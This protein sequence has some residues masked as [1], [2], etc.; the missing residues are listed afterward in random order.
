MKF[1]ENFKTA[2]LAGLVVGLLLGVVDATA[3]ISVLSFEW[4]EL[5]QAILIPSLMFIVGFSLLSLPVQSVLFIFKLKPSKRNLTSF[6]V[7][8]LF[9][10]L[11]PVLLFINTKNDEQK[12]RYKFIFVFSIVPMLTLALFWPVKMF[13]HVYG[14]APIVLLGVSVLFFWALRK[15]KLYKAIA[16]ILLILYMSTNLVSWVPFALYSTATSDPALDLCY[17]FAPSERKDID[18]DIIDP[19]DRCWE[20]VGRSLLIPGVQFPIMYFLYE[21]THDY[22]GTNEGIVKFLNQ[23]AKE[24]DILFTAKEYY[25]LQFYTELRVLS[26][27]EYFD[28]EWLESEN[29]TK[30]DWIV[31]RWPKYYPE[32]YLEDY[33]L[34]NEYIPIE[35]PYPSFWHG[36]MPFITK[37]H[38]WTQ[39]DADNVIIYQRPDYDDS[40]Q[41]I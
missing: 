34:Q 18:G 14:F 11:F 32:D 28:A 39:K 40:A 9:L 41:G 3:R 5:Y 8:I 21:I 25:P 33:A 31:S 24:G 26:P 7:P 15:G 16:I 12:F 29:I 19:G 35:I 37:H 6:Y 17:K 23:N 36:N 38:Y 22:D 1:L 27:S 2:A 20:Y 13:K 10:L 4:F 30:P